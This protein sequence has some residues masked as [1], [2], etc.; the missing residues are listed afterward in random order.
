MIA[1]AMGEAG[2]M[3]RVL[4]GKFGAFLTFATLPD[5]AKSAPGQVSLADMIGLYRFPKISSATEV[6][7]V[8]PVGHSMSPAIHNAGFAELGLDKVYVLLPVRPGYENLAAALDQMREFEALHFRG[9]SVTI[10]HKEDAL[11]WAENQTPE[12]YWTGE[13]LGAKP[14]RGAFGAVNTLTAIPNFREWRVDNTDVD[15]V[16]NLLI[17][18]LLTQV[19]DLPRPISRASLDRVRENRRGQLPNFLVLGAGGVARAACRAVESVSTAEFWHAIPGEAPQKLDTRLL[20]TNR[21]FDRAVSLAAEKGIGRA[22]L[23]NEREWRGPYDF[24]INCTSVGMTPNVD[25]T[26][27]PAHA[28]SPKTVVFDTVYNPP[29]TRL[30]REAKAAGCRTISGV[31]MFIE[32]AVAQFKLWTGQEAPRDKMA[33]I[34]RTRLGAK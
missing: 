5:G 24:I 14:V 23:W 3:T 34:V 15:A 20:V 27:V 4:A 28:L 25:E 17:K 33:Q 8:M 6:Y 22:V 30:L 16:A 10:P 18:E 7:G 19:P 9:A 12:E 2:I 29:E 13:W 11:K 32:Q 26:P 1:L 21:S 31:D